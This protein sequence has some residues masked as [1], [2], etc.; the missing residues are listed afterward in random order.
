MGK[1]IMMLMEKNLET[2]P[3]KSVIQKSQKD[4]NI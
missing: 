3:I 2:S 1:F 4:N